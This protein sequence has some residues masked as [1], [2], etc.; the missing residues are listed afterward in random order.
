MLDTDIAYIAGL[1]DGEAYIG[2]KRSKAYKCTGR[3]NPGY[4][5]RIQIR[6]VDEDAIKFIA[7]NLGG[8]YF[9]ETPHT[10]NGRPLFCYQASDQRAEN[11]L[12]T[13]LPYLRVKKRVAETVLQLRELQKQSAQYR[14]KITGYRNFPNQYGTVRKVP[15]LSY[16]DEYI[17]MCNALYERCK[18][19]NKVG[20]S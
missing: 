16:T 19:L 6:M 10:K 7:E 5:A 18:E 8:W 3:K 2:I 12:K 11:I 20:T 14:T 4:H 15:N 17:E 13:V 1:F 9:K